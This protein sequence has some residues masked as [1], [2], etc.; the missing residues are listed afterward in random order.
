MSRVY[1]SRNLTFALQRMA[2]LAARGYVRHVSGE[3]QPEKAETVVNKFRRLYP[4]DDSPSQARARRKRGEARCRLTLWPTDHFTFGWAI[5]VTEGNGLIAEREPLQDGCKV[6]EA[7]QAGGYEL[8]R[9]PHPGR[10]PAWSWRKPPLP[11]AT[12]AGHACKLARHP[13]PKAAQE[14]IRMEM[15]RPGFA[16]TIVQRWAL[17]RAMQKA[18]KRARHPELELPKRLLYLRR[19]KRPSASLTM[20]ARQMI[21]YRGVKAKAES[22]ATQRRPGTAIPPKADPVSTRPVSR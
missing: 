10:K 2:D 15:Q 19:M 7:L 11:W 21:I 13:S 12:Y 17:F 22:K 4:L 3:V 14:L 16:G 18:R 5:Q 6:R 1:V 9:L 8:V 20:M